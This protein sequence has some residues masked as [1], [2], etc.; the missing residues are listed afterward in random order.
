MENLKQNERLAGLI[1]ESMIR[2]RIAET[3]IERLCGLI[4]G[5]PHSN[6]Y[7]SPQK[8][9]CTDSAIIVADIKVQGAERLDFDEA[10]D[11]LID[12]LCGRCPRVRH[13]VFLCFGEFSLRKY[14][15]F[16]A[17]LESCR[18]DR[19]VQVIFYQWNQNRLLRLPY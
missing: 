19:G 17:T 7:P 11:A 6:F 8:G 12:H 10:F 18:R 1:Q 3:D 5:D 2:K 9:A 16:Q 14:E 15:R 4:T 13:V